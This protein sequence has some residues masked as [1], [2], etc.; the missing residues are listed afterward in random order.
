MN[1]LAERACF[2]QV[3][4]AFTVYADFE[5]YAGGVYAHTAG[6][7]MGAHAVK[8]M[9]WGT[10]A[11]A[12]YWL[13]ANSWNSYWGEKGTFRIARGEG[14][15]C[16]MAFSAVASSADAKWHTPKSALLPSADG[17]RAG[18]VPPQHGDLSHAEVTATGAAGQRVADWLCTEVNS[19]QVRKISSW[20]RSWANFSLF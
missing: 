12:D 16:G 19:R 4:A 10:D 6:R 13:A 3:T 1:P 17:Q 9:G 8:M 20:P 15:D 18:A 5:N 2:P 11:G 14:K 7:M